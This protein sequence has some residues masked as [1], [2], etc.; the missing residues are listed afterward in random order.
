MPT[1]VYRCLLCN[2]EFEVKQ[3]ITKIADIRC[4]E[5]GGSTERLIVNG[6]HIFKTDGFYNTDYKE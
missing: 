1:Y 6:N 3:K 2:Y 5:C 4:P